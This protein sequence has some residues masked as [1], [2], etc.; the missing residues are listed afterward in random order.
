MYIQKKAIHLIKKKSLKKINYKSK[1][2][3]TAHKAP[4]PRS[5]LI[6]F[7]H[8][9]SLSKCLHF[10]S[11]EPLLEAF[12]LSPFP[13]CLM[14]APEGK[15]EAKTEAKPEA[16]EKEVEEKETQEH[17]KYKVIKLVLV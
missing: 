15:T 17:L 14:A 12:H 13:Y 6:I 8:S 16:N 5:C 7:P 3:L 10:T 2:L 11:E 4:N 1:E 9:I